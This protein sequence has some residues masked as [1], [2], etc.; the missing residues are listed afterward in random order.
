MLPSNASG[1][2]FRG[3]LKELN[4]STK[5][6]EVIKREN[7]QY[8]PHLGRRFKCSKKASMWDWGPAH[9][10]YLHKATSS[11]WLKEYPVLS[12]EH[13]FRD[14]LIWFPWQCGWE[15]SIQGRRDQKLNDFRPHSWWVPAGEPSV[16]LLGPFHHAKNWLPSSLPPTSRK[17][18][19]M[20]WFFLQTRPMDI[21]KTSWGLRSIPIQ[22]TGV[23]KNFYRGQLLLQNQILE[24]NS[25]TENCDYWLSR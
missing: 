5:Q 16:L 2:L 22:Q 8:V 14:Y 17:Y 21:K 23:R 7:L 3:V 24:K 12:T 25:I 9:V 1:I 11:T 19:I 18:S 13:I 10:L 6:G 15:F 20:R 4:T